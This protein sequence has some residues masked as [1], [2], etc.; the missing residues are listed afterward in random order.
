MSKTGYHGISKV[1]A[2][3][4]PRRSECSDQTKR[5]GHERPCRRQGARIATSDVTTCQNADRLPGSL[6]V[7]QSDRQSVRRRA[8]HLVSQVQR[9]QTRPGHDWQGQARAA[10]LD[11]ELKAFDLFGC[12]A[13]NESG[14]HQT[15]GR[16]RRRQINGQ[17]ANWRNQ[18]MKRRAGRLAEEREWTHMAT[19]DET[20]RARM[21]KSV[22][23]ERWF[24]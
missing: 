2:V 12:V 7:C 3:R 5:R 11:R 17:T 13:R 20:K 14:A 19:A 9:G 18:V 23:N 4:A 10:L 15:G 24:E 6:S 1:R 16:G 21:G 8:S 22:G